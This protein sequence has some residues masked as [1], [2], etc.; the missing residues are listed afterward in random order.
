MQLRGKKSKVADK[1][2]RCSAETTSTETVVKPPLITTDRHAELV[3]ACPNHRLS[4]N[5]ALDLHTKLPL[6]FHVPLW[7]G[8][9]SSKFSV[10]LITESHES[11]FLQSTP[12]TAEST[13]SRLSLCL[14]GKAREPFFFFSFLKRRY[15]GGRQMQTAQQREPRGQDVS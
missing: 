7:K 8:E 13:L 11:K 14:H 10:Q 3:P 12:R 9:G 2:L 4:L 5:K 6:P 1:R 15:W